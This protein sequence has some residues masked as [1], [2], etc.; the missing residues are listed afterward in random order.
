M[1]FKYYHY[2]YNNKKTKFEVKTKLRSVT[3]LKKAKKILADNQTAM[4]KIKE[5]YYAIVSSVDAIEEKIN[6]LN[7]KERAKELR[8]LTSPR[9]FKLEVSI[10]YLMEYDYWATLYINGEV[11]ESELT[12]DLLPWNPVKDQKLL[13]DIKTTLKEEFKFR[14]GIDSFNIVDVSE[15]IDEYHDKEEN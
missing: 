10:D 3:N 1:K 14:E 6:R 15:Y 12:G 8:N 2:K 4:E 5:Q 11:V 13:N 7:K 9:E